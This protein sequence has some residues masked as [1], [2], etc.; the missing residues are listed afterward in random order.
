MGAKDN[1]KELNSKLHILKG[2]L[3][4][5]TKKAEQSLKDLQP[6]GTKTVLF[7]GKKAVIQ[8]N[9]NGV[10]NMQFENKKKGFE[11]FHELKE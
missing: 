7:N 5:M 8:I 4:E 9:G 6:V 3:A 11:Y 1:T 2:G 10:L